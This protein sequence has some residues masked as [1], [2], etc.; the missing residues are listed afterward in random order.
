MYLNYN[1]IN[2]E[3]LWYD[4]NLFIWYISYLNLNLYIHF[5]YESACPLRVLTL[6]K[7]SSINI[8][9]S[10]HSFP[11]TKGFVFSPDQ[12]SVLTPKLFVP[13]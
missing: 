13:Y 6:N 10:D 2:H 5:I 12:H 1:I 8:V 9:L 11:K 3:Y 7:N 4:R